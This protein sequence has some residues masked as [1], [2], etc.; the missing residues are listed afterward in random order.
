MDIDYREVVYRYFKAK[1]EGSLSLMTLLHNGGKY[2]SSNMY[3][4]LAANAYDTA[5]YAQPP[6][7]DMKEP[8]PVGIVLEKSS[9]IEEAGGYR[10]GTPIVGI[11]ISS[12]RIENAK[13]FVS[14]LEN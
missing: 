2:D 9:I 11:I 10:D 13:Q 5:I 12:G 8:I 3:A 14:F 4:V 1:E 7:E 6:L